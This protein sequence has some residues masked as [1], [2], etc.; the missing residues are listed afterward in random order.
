MS[1]EALCILAGMTPIIIKTEEAVKQYNIRKGKGSQTHLFDSRVE[2]NNLPHPA[3]A[4][5][6]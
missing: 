4:I 2:F 1:S 3:Y 6:L 5:K